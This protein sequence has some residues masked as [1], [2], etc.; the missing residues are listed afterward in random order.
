MR[1]DLSRSLKNG[2]QHSRTLL[3]SFMAVFIVSLLGWQ[4]KSSDLGLILSVLMLILICFDL[5]FF[6]DP[7]R[8]AAVPENGFVA[9]ADGKVVAIEKNAVSP[10]NGDVC[11]K[12]S[13]FLSLFDVHVNRVPFEGRVAAIKHNP[14]HFHAAFK[15]KASDLNEHVLVELQTKH[16]VLFIKQIAGFIARRIV[17]FISAE[18]V[19]QTGERFGLIKFGSRVEL[20]LPADV[21]LYV[22]AGEHVRAG[23]SVL[24]R[25]SSE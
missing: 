1:N 24:G 19:V 21:E 11:I 20:F 13:I 25:F 15:G 9:P 4:W 2:W 17:N 5:F 18:S 14:G 22:T 8:V 12:V 6:R 10:A 3:T 7:E 16:G 23:K